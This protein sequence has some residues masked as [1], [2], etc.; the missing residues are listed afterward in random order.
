MDVEETDE[1][2][3]TPRVLTA[4]L[5]EFSSVTDYRTLRDS[6]PQ[7]LAIQLQCR[8]VLLYFQ[9]EEL[10][11]LVASSFGEHGENV[12]W[13]P[14]LLSVAH[15]HPLNIHSGVPEACA[16]RE[17]RQIVLPAD[18]PAFVAVPLIYRQ[19]SIGVLVVV[20]GQREIDCPATW[21]KD[22]LALLDAVASVVAL[23]LENSRLLERD[24]ERIYEL[25]LLNSISSQMN[26]SL[27][28]VARLRSIVLQ[29][30]REIAHVDVCALLEITREADVPDWLP[31][32]LWALLVQQAHGQHMLTP[33]VIERDKEQSVL[34]GQHE[35][36]TNDYLTFLPEDIKTFFAMPL[37]SVRTANQHRETPV[38]TERQTSQKKSVS[39][40]LGIIVAGYYR[41][42][43]MRR[44][45]L[46]LLQILSSQI[47]A[48]WENMLLMEEVVEARNE[49]R[50]LL[51]QVLDDQRTKELI[52][53]SIPSGLIT[54]DRDGHVTTFNRAAATVLGYHPYE[55]LGL[56]L[57]KILPSRHTSALS[58]S[59]SPLL[60]ISVLPYDSY[61]LSSA[62]GNEQG[63]AE[64]MGVWHGTIITEDRYHRELV[65]DV[66]MTPL[67]NDH[68][69][70]V[71]IL[72]TFNDMT[73]MHR[74]E[75]E[76][77]RLDR[78][79]SLGEMA[80]NVAHEVRNPLASIKT[81]MQ[82]LRDDLEQQEFLY[83]DQDDWMQESVEVVLKEVERLDILV[84]D[85]LLFARPR[86]LH[87]VQCDL[88]AL[89]DQVLSLLHPQ[90]QEANI[91]L[92]RVY[93][94][95]PVVWVDVGQMEQILLNI[96]KNALQAMPE[97][98]IITIACRCLGAESYVHAACATTSL[99]RERSNM[100]IK[101]QESHT[102]WVE[103]VVSDTGSGM[104]PDQLAQIFQPFYTTKAHGI[105]LG[106]PITRRLIE[107][108]GG[109]LRVESQ[110]GYGTTITI[111][112]PVLSEEV[113]EESEVNVA[114]KSV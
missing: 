86:Q 85:L 102:Q 47:S 26:H 83:S 95:V 7:R 35:P 78:L 106:L 103:L 66:D 57:H 54:T 91:D 80:A 23:L 101:Q 76:K 34:H 20:R 36:E 100:Q 27:Y 63:H 89:C 90:L 88:V 6:I 79:A 105:G 41:P 68:G 18:E 31:P 59:E 11:Q 45:E 8:Y 49:A 24:R 113:G 110:L 67:Y 82:M 29:R 60:N 99:A 43:K 52:L 38:H 12:D 53:E 9:H 42:W 32:E 64:H 15:M 39:K 3:C 92:H 77:R 50:R 17:R 107:D 46:T 48:A 72:T 112:L 28:D 4:L 70:R 22:E 21:S 75:E 30:T 33:F 96:Y 2:G 108:H 65:L 56:S 10:L 16:W 109:S 69:E 55:V 104:S 81:S 114:E 44:E 97:G 62:E 40:V 37:Y 87:R 73:S 61:V 94:A 93:E 13:P 71:G 58:S 1:L 111:H 98:G 19:R 5:H 74:L 84:R 25:S 14:S 51:L